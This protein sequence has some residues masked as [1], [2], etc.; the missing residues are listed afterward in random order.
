MPR[1]YSY[2]LRW[3]DGAAPNPFWNLCS[4]VICKS[5]IR[6]SATEGD[7]VAGT[8][9]RNGPAGNLS[10]KR[11]YAMRV[12]RKMTMEAY[13]RFTQQEKVEKIPDRRSKDWRRWLGDSIYDFSG[14]PPRQRPGVHGR[15]E[16]A[17]D[18]SGTFALLSSDFKYFG[19]NPITIPDGLIP[20]V[21]EGRGYRSTANDPYVGQFVAW[22]RSLGDGAPFGRPQ[23]IPDRPPSADSACSVGRRLDDSNDAPVND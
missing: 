9:S 11:V 4:L 1:L 10:G 22:I 23:W 3:D 5:G 14:T 7:W 15:S 18:L 21:L 12:T 19:D 6:S 20:I 2:V 13:D 17:R 16:Q 8:G